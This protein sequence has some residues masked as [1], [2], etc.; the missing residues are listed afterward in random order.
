MKNKTALGTIILFI[1]ALI[2]GLAF[3]FQR[4]GMESVGPLTFMAARC[5]FAV[6][7]LTVLLLV[8]R[9]PKK[10]F[11]F[12]RPTAIGGVL[13]GILMTLANNAQQIGMVETS[14]GKAGF[15]TAMYILLVPLFNTLIFGVKEKP[16]VWTGVFFGTVGMYLLCVTRDFSIEASDIWVLGCAVL[17]SGHIL[18]S[19]KY[20]QK[21]DV[22]Q[23]SFIQFVV[24]L[25]ID[26]LL[27]VSF[28]DISLSGLL[29]ARVPILYC[30]LLSAGVGYTFQ[31]IGQKY[32]KPT[33]ASL[34][35]SLESVF[36]VL[37]GWLILSES[38]TARELC[39]C[40]VMF[41]AIMLVKLT[42]NKEPLQEESR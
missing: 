19:D 3:V 16:I 12:D 9:G 26:I 33:A 23:M 6:I 24:S 13:C 2:W 38:F 41:C 20:A 15:I 37:A 8:L 5:F 34:I 17:F 11:R 29:N 25:V 21:A 32:V 35:M 40:I 28:E 27:A 4:T 39:G 14:A 10:A 31:L 36:A 1:T 42:E 30:G 18:C 22:I 7:F